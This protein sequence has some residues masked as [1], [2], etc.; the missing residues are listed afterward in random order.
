MS[1]TARAEWWR[2]ARFL[3]VGGLNTAVGFLL[4]ALFVK[5]GLGP[6]GA[7]AAA[8]VGGVL[9]N[10]QSIGRLVFARSG[11]GGG[12]RARVFILVYAVQFCLNAAAL[13]V[14][15]A[16]GTGPL[17]AQALLLPVFAIGSFLAMR[18]FVY[19][20]GATR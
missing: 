4:F 10:Y 18:R 11:P 19:G 6:T 12:G 16:S 9:F 1:P 17:V 2:F 8:T 5:L 3:A 13:R 14:L 15:L 20:P 7:L